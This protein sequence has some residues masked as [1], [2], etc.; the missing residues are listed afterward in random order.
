MRSISKNHACYLPLLY[1][2]ISGKVYGFLKN[3][4]QVLES[5]AFLD[6]YPSCQFTLYS[7]ICKFIF[8]YITLMHIY[9]KCIVDGS[10]W[11]VRVGGMHKW[12]EISPKILNASLQYIGC[13]ITSCFICNARCVLK[14]I[15]L[16]YC[17]TRA[18]YIAM[19]MKRI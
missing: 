5:L 8:Y 9:F 4:F 14:Y 3:F 15:T 10:E 7:E 17:D 2:H 13:S 1:M 11:M 6:S 12:S 19:N 18:E 16:F